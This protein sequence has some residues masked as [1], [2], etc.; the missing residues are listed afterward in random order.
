[1]EG[2]VPTAWAGAVTIGLL[3]VLGVFV[4]PWLLKRRLGGLALVAGTGVLTALFF[5]FDR[6]R[7]AS[8]GVSAL[9]ALLWAAAPAITGVIVHRI[10]RKTG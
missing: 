8:G 2:S 9:L 4:Y 10:Q 3:V 5:W 6:G 7:G 1:M